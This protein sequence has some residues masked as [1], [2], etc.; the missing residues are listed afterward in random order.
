[1]LIP[2]HNTHTHTDQI[3][4]SPIYWNDFVIDPKPFVQTIIETLEF[5]VYKRFIARF[6]WVNWKMPEFQLNHVKWITMIG[7]LFIWSHFHWA[8]TVNLFCAW[9]DLKRNTGSWHFIRANSIWLSWIF[10][11]YHRIFLAAHTKE[12][13]CSSELP[14]RKFNMFRLNACFLYDVNEHTTLDSS[15]ES[16][17]TKFTQTIYLNGAEHTH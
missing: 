3:D 7:N 9:I 10:F 2:S 15:M 17:S 6:A 8:S 14:A 12:R 11:F 1:M 16:S 13:I 5:P 4:D